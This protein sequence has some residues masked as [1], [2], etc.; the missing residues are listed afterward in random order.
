MCVD[1]VVLVVVDVGVWLTCCVVLLCYVS[2][3]CCVYMC[4]AVMFIFHD[5]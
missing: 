3:R 1:A 2:I 5:I 4:V